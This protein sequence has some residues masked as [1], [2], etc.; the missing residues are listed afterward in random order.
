V[1]NNTAKSSEVLIAFHLLITL[2]HMKVLSSL[3]ADEFQKR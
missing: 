3:V 2:H 1:D